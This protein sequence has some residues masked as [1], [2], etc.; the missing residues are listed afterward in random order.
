MRTRLLGGLAVLTAVLTS[1]VPGR[2]QGPGLYSGGL[3][4]SGGLPGVPSENVPLPLGNPGSHGFYGF[5]EGGYYFQTRTMRDQTIAYRGLV[6]STGA[7]TGLPGT[8]IGSG[9]VA[10]STSDFGRRSY[11][12]AV[13]FGIG[14]KTDDGTSI[15]ARFMALSP[16]DYN[17]SATLASQYARS[18]P[19]LSDTYLTA[20]VFNFGPE[21]GGPGRKTAFEGSTIFLPFI[22]AN[23]NLQL[24][25]QLGDG[26][27]YGIWN[28][29]STMTITYR[30]NYQEA[31]IGARVPLFQ[32]ETSRIYALGGGRFNWFYEKFAWRTTSYDVNGG[33][34]PSWQAVYTNTLSQRMY[35]P[36]AGVGHDI[37]LGSRFALSTDLTGALLLNVAKERA[38]YKLA[39]NTTSAKQSVN[40]LRLVPSAGANFN[41]WWYPIQGVQVRMGYSANTW[42]NTKNMAEPVGFNLGAIDPGYGNQAFRIIHGVNFGIGLFF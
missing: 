20:G 32:T 13:N 41:L 7:V 3:S 12:P 21:Y 28:G 23:G 5:V 15:T 29:A 22:D 33:T 9:Q 25:Q 42:F 30:Q 16:V 37:Y 14:Y 40:E 34:L 38:K 18:R 35:G 1:A 4:D 8:Y 11:A 17:A 10:L 27:F 2:A 26:L 19:D 39:D 6:D 31:E 36:Y 24:R